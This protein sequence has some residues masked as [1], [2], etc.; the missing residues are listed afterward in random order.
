MKMQAVGLVETLGSASAVMIVD[1]MLKTSQV[2][3]EC[4][5]T[6]CGGHVTV[7]LSGDVSA[8]TAA[9]EAVK[10]NPPGGE[11]IA[12]AVISAPSQET[13]R[14]IELSR[15][16]KKSSLN[17]YKK[18]TSNEVLFLMNMFFNIGNKSFHCRVFF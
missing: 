16:K 18:R 7:F 9:V 15:K 5:N 10:A 6:K 8:V 3:Y 11:I 12:A 17:R 1:K 14:M 2:T 4:W 13:I